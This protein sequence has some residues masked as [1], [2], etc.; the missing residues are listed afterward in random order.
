ME[1]ATFISL[2]VENNVPMSDTDCKI[3]LYKEK[4]NCY[5]V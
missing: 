1:K 5:N 3:S 2:N 4:E